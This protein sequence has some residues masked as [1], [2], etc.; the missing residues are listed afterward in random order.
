MIRITYQYVCEYCGAAD[1]K[2]DYIA[3][4]GVVIPVP[5]SDDYV[6]FGYAHL[7]PSCAD[8]AREVLKETQ[9]GTR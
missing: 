1:E 8:R 9:G 7:C 3:A 2:Q 5:H 4:A 6:A